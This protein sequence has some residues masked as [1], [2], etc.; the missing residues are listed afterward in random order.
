MKVMNLSLKDQ[1]RFVTGKMLAVLITV[2]LLCPAAGYSQQEEE[3]VD[4]YDRQ[5]Q[6]VP[7]DGIGTPGTSP[8]ENS[9]GATIG[10]RD[11][12]TGSSTAE[13]TRQG[14]RP[15]QTPAGAANRPASTLDRNP[16]GNP[17]VPF[18]DNMNLAFLAAGVG[19]A[20]FVMRK[21]LKL[22]EA[23]VSGK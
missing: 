17:D 6:V 21:K 18:D 4:S 16:G 22:K 19:F 5:D 14:N 7:A 8:W 13:G 23:L 11:E 1:M 10:T 12:N 9:A 2:I 15:G 20:F 3:E